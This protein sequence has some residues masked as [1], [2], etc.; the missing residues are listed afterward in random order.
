MSKWSSLSSSGFL[1]SISC[2]VNGITI[3]FKSMQE[4][5]VA[6]LTSSFP[7][8]SHCNELQSLLIRPPNIIPT[9]TES[10]FKLLSLVLT[11]ENTK[12]MATNPSSAILAASSFAFYA[13]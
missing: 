6:S 10:V 1:I 9:L 7:L 4:R 5:L 8:I 11:I 12:N 3:D 2:V 13:L